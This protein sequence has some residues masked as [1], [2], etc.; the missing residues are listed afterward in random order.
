VLVVVS[1]L[2]APSASSRRRT[3]RHRPRV[4]FGTSILYGLTCMWCIIAFAGRPDFKLPEARPR[5]GVG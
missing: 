4:E 3:H 5:A 1:T 2:I